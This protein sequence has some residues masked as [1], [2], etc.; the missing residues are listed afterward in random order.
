MHSESFELSVKV[1]ELFLSQDISILQLIY[2]WSVGVAAHSD[3]YIAAC[4]WFPLWQGRLNC[5]G[6]FRC[7]FFRSSSLSVSCRVLCV[8]VQTGALC[9]CWGWARWTPRAWCEHWGRRPCC[10]MWVLLKHEISLRNSLCHSIIPLAILMRSL[11]IS[12]WLEH[13]WKPVV[14]VPGVLFPTAGWWWKGRVPGSSCDYWLAFAQILLHLCRASNS[15]LCSCADE[16]TPH[17]GFCQACTPRIRIIYFLKKVLA[18]SSTFSKG[19]TQTVT[20]DLLSFQTESW[21][22]SRS[23]LTFFGSW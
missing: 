16:K 12:F 17:S 5:C 20:V 23:A 18:C 2:R 7:A 4:S 21:Q 22:N 9:T 10:A 6:L 13:S 11:A 14:A 15:S 8:S 3:V 19:I 1:R